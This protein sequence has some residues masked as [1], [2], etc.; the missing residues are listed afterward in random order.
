MSDKINLNK[1]GKRQCL[2]YDFLLGLSV[3]E[4]CRRIYA[5]FVQDAMNERT[6]RWWCDRFRS[7]NYSLEDEF[8]PS[9]PTEIDDEELR[10]VVERLLLGKQRAN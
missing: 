4:S 1:C 3:A 7:G 9:R 5:A 8:R 10:L 2:L 6:A